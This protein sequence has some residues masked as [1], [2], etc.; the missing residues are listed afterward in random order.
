LRKLK[1]LGSVHG[2]AWIRAGKSALPQQV[3]DRSAKITLDAV[4]LT[5][6]FRLHD[7]GGKRRGS[8]LRE[9]VPGAA[10][11]RPVLVFS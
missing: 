6:T 3:H 8:F 7:G 11:D 5:K 1:P 10:F 2:M 9:V 4:R